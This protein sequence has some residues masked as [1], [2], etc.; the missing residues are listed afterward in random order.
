MVSM[1]LPLTVG[2]GSRKDALK[3]NWISIDPQTFGGGWASRFTGKAS[4]TPWGPD[5]SSEADLVTALKNALA[6]NGTFKDL[7]TRGGADHVQVSVPAQQLA[8][9]SDV[10]G[11]QLTI[12]D[13]LLGC[14][15][16]RHRPGGAFRP[17]RCPSARRSR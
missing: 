5:A 2:Y 11:Q 8:P 1:K 9:L 14:A 15:F 10:A 16:T 13:L 7:G 12:R 17:R 4:G 3:G 6:H